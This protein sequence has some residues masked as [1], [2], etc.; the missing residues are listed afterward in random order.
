MR[1]SS[2][3][4]ELREIVRRFLGEQVPSEY[5]RSRI[6]NGVRR[7][8]AFFTSLAE[9]GLE[10]GFGG[11]SPMFSLEELSLIAH[12]C[13]YALVP[14]PV[15]EQLLCSAILPRVMSAPER[16]GF[17][18]EFAG[19]V[20]SIAASSCSALHLNSTDGTVSGAV[21]WAWGGEAAERIVAFADTPEGRRAVV[22]LLNQHGV[23]RAATTSLDLTV[24]LIGVSAQCVKALVCSRETTAAIEDTL[25]ALKAAEAAGI[26]DRVLSMTCD[27][28][29]TREQFGRPIGSFQAVQQKLADL[30]AASESL[31]SLSRFA[32][33]ASVH[34]P[35]QRPLTSRAAVLLG[36]ETAP[37]VCEG[38]I[39]CH[40][41]MGFTWEYDLHLYLRRAK[42]IQAAFGLSEAR[43]SEL[44][45]RVA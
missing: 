25:E 12:E 37:R 3:Q 41:G 29:K 1:L 23:I 27:Y 9:L 16:A 31:Q 24:A 43:A 28:V 19:A 10:E 45:G 34:A 26:C 2:D 17:C 13:G 21:V 5:L 7:D 38:A 15:I 4:N 22:F 35:S 44:L 39:Q 30:Y 33:W 36:C 18:G 20:T 8:P 11:D 14:E 42:T 40:G 32:A 6:A